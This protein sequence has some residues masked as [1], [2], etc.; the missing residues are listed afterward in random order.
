MHS[1]ATG[2]YGPPSGGAMNG[3]GNGANGTYGAPPSA[4]GAPSAADGAYG[5]PAAQ[6]S[7]KLSWHLSCGPQQLTV[8]CFPC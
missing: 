7:L 3:N 5:Q 8:L 4:Y 6:A 2:A 1:Q